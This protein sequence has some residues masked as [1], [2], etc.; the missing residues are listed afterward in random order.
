LVNFNSSGDARRKFKRNRTV[1]VLRRYH[2]VVWPPKGSIDILSSVLD[3]EITR[4]NPTE[5]SGLLS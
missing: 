5:L 4:R 3:V 2:D 1:F